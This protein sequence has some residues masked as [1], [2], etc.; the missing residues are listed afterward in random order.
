MGEAKQQ[1]IVNNWINKNNITF[2][3][4]FKITGRYIFNDS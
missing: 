3:N 4:L 1:E 2:K